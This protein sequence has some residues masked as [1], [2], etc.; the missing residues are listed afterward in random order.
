LQGL[1]VMEGLVLKPSL[2]TKEEHKEIEAKL[3]PT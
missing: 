1:P 3:K 2:I